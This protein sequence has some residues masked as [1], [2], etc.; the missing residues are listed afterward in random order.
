MSSDY[1][2]DSDVTLLHAGSRPGDS[3]TRAALPAP[4]SYLPRPD[5]DHNESDSAY[6]EDSLLRDDTK[7]LASHITEYRY[8]F[9]RRY[10]AFRDGAYWVGAGEEDNTFNNAQGSPGK[11][12]TMD[13]EADVWE[14]CI[15]T[16]RRGRE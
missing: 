12:Q 4:P 16:K 3:L 5:D 14:I 2:E 9:G 8:E 1:E 11:F 6:G 13:H 7:T 15:G 10:H